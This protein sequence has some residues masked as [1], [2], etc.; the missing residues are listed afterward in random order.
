M[1]PGRW[2]KLLRLGRAKQ[3]LENS[4]LTVKEVIALVGINDMSHFDRDFRNVYGQTPS[5]IR[6]KKSP[7]QEHEHFG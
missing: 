1:P 4:F 5:Q 7:S 3:L 6:L 2:L